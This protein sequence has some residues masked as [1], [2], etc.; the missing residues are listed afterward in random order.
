M[1]TATRV[2]LLGP[3]RLIVVAT[4]AVGA[5]VLFFPARTLLLQRD[6]IDALEERATALKSENDRLAQEA[7]RLS[8]PAEIEALARDRLGVARPGER[9]YFVEPSND[10]AARALAEEDDRSVWSR[11]WSWFTSLV[12]GRN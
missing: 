5:F 7:A 10:P 1:T 6:R 2:S 9:A 4:L 8:D 11:V 12:R 3:R